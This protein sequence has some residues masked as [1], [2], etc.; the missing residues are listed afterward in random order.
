MV[1]YSKENFFVRYR[2]FESLAH[3]N[4]LAEKWL[5]EVAD[6]RLHVTVKE[7]VAER[8]AC[9]APYPQASAGCAIPLTRSGGA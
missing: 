5:K 4:Q 2:K 3:L 9:E 8:F 6:P 1:R 7:I